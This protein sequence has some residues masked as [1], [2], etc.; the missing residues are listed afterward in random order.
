MRS[1]IAEATLTE[2][3]SDFCRQKP[4]E[5]PYLVPQERG[6][7]CICAPAGMA[8]TF[9]GSI[10]DHP[11]DA[12]PIG[13]LET[14]RVASDIL[15]IGKANGNKGLFQRLRQYMRYGFDTGNNHRGGRAIFQI[16]GYENLICKWYPCEDCE[17]VERRL[18]EDFKAQY[19]TYPLANWRR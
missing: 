4:L 8:I 5:R 10:D 2:L 14:K 1:E 15:Y 19:G 9:K 7:Y 16:E 12:Y 3:W 6:V 17:D 18:L 13:D 11:G